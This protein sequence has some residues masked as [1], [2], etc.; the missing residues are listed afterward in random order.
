MPRGFTILVAVLLVAPSQPSHAQAAAPI[1]A[2]AP[3]R[4]ESWQAAPLDQD[5]VPS[6][7]KIITA[8]SD[9]NDDWLIAGAVGAAA[10]IV[11]CTAV[12][13][14]IDDSARRGLSFCPLDTYLIIGGVG[15]VLGAAIGAAF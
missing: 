8:G 3:L 11:F 15:F 2:T 4:F 9:K 1:P 14:M 13:T 5:S 7:G 6:A 10:G 12:S